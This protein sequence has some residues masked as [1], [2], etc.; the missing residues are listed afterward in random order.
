MKRILRE[1]TAV[2]IRHYTY[3]SRT[4]GF[5]TYV[6]WRLQQLDRTRSDLAGALVEAQHWKKESSEL[7]QG[8]GVAIEDLLLPHADRQ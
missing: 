1:H 7:I 5:S 6:G 3:V 4:I 2:T 8:L